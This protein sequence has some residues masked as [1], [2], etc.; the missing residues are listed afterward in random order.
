M[1]SAK[2]LGGGASQF[3][4]GGGGGGGAKAPP[5]PLP[6]INPDIGIN[7]QPSKCMSHV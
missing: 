2:I 6:E 3:S 7:H 5:G 4:R 1:P